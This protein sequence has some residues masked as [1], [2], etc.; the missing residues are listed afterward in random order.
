MT[1]MIS[2]LLTIDVAHP[3]RRP[4]DVE[5]ELVRT[6][7]LIRNTPSLRIIKIIHG[8]GS[9]GKGGATRETVRNW[10]FNNR[11]KFRAI[12]NGE[13]YGL[14]NTDVQDMRIE[15]G[16]FEDTDIDAANAGLTIVWVR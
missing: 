14:E 2:P 4:A 5:D 7:N 3:P 10:V 13:E 11:G 15:V 12:I 6:W 8:Y 16:Q 9:A 1:R